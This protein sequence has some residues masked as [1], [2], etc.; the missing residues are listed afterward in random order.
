VGSGFSPGIEEDIDTGGPLAS[1]AGDCSLR[2]G[3]IRPTAG[4]STTVDGGLS[5]DPVDR[6]D[7]STTVDCRL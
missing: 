2:S 6:L 5:A 7:P 4:L 1:L 3:G